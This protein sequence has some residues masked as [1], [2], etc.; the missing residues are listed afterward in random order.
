MRTSHKLRKI[1]FLKNESGNLNQNC[2]STTM[3][4][5][6]LSAEVRKSVC[7]SGVSQFRLKKSAE[8]FRSKLAHENEQKKLSEDRK[9]SRQ[10]S[11]HLK[12]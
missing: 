2:I 1:E 8:N 12:A 11:Y 10:L 5:L 7:L 3:R 4:S 6:K 9:M